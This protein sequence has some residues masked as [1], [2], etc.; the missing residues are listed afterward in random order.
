MTG[1]G[2][3]ANLLSASGL[4]P[5]GDTDVKR[6]LNCTGPLVVLLVG[7]M[8]GGCDMLQPQVAAPPKP[9]DPPE[10]YVDLP[11]TG[12]ITDYED[13]TGRTV[14]IKTIEIRARVTGY[15]DKIN[16][17]E[18]EGGDVQEGSVL[19]EIDPRPYDHEVLRTKANLLQAE[20]HL[21]R[22]NLDYRRM[23]K[24]VGDKTVSREQ[25]DL[26]AGDRSEAQATVESAK[27]NLARAQLDVTFT[28][29][30]APMS[31]R[32]S[33]TQLDPG[34]LVRADET[35]LTTIV[36][37]DPVYAY[38][39]VDERTMLRIRRYTEEGRVKSEKDQGVPVTMGLADEQGYPHQGI[40]NFVDN[41][42]DPSTGTLQVRGIFKN[43]DH[44]LSPGLFVRVRLPIGQPYHAVLVSEQA[45]GTDQGQKFVYVIDGD[46]KAQ[47]R[48]VQ[49]GKLQQGRRVILKGLSEGERVVVSGLQ[50]VRPGAA[51]QP[52]LMEST[53][54]QSRD[55]ASEV[56][57]ATAPEAGLS[58]K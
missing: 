3:S 27:A 19:F 47:Y 35:V 57:E 56:V 17:K 33:R 10:V 23:E 21:R 34:N 20:A 55:E 54:Q 22:L 13:F 37:T 14:A 53:A 8:L 30:L 28:K 45:L 15:L 42:L 7:A 40:V 48:R 16:F 24:L 41:R 44:M 32:V 11:T 43:S 58:R 12:E 5:V 2:S 26:V 49:V 50:R 31:G 9:P 38:F 29:V 4:L 51:V 46:N 25:F 6:F 52:K 18:K 36:G 1:K 39:E